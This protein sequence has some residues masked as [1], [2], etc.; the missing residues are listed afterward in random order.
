MRRSSGRK[1]RKK[2]REQREGEGRQGRRDISSYA[3]VVAV[4]RD[5]RDRVVRQGRTKT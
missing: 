2:V 3:V 5:G 4:E 1:R